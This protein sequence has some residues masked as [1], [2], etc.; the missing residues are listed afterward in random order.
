MNRKSIP[1]LVIFLIVFSSFHVSGFPLHKEN[2]ILAF[3]EPASSTFPQQVLSFSRS[4]IL[5]ASIDDYISATPLAAKHHIPL[6]LVSHPL[7]R[8][9]SFL[10]LYTP[11]HVY[12]VG[13]TPFDAT[14]LTDEDLLVETEPSTTEYVIIAKKHGEFSIVGDYLCAYHQGT[15]IYAD[16]L[17]D[18]I[19]LET[20]Q[21]CLPT[22][23]AL[24]W[25]PDEFECSAYV[26]TRLRFTCSLCT[27]TMPEFLL[28][29]LAR[30]D[31]DPYIDAT[32]GFITGS[33]VT[34]AT[35][36]LAR[37]IVYDDLMGD[38]KHNAL[39]APGFSTGETLCDTLD[40][41]YIEKEQESYHAQAFLDALNNGVKYAC[42]FGHGTPI[43]LL[44]DRT[45]NASDP[46]ASHL[47]SCPQAHQYLINRGEQSVLIPENYTIFPTIFC[48]EACLTGLTGRVYDKK[49]GDPLTYDCQ[50]FRNHSISLTL[51][52]SGAAAYIGSSTIGGIGATY[53]YLLASAYN[54]SL[55]DI[56]THMN[57]KFIAHRLSYFIIPLYLYKYDPRIVLFG[58]PAFNPSHDIQTTCEDYYRVTTQETRLFGSEQTTRVTIQHLNDFDVSFG[59]VEITA[60]TADTSSSLKL[61]N[62]VLLLNN[63]FHIHEFVSEELVGHRI[64]QHNEKIILYW[65]IDHPD[66]GMNTWHI[67]VTPER[68][69]IY[70]IDD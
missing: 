15:I 51:I 28:H 67:L 47:V 50:D 42:F 70:T 9:A 21:D 61:S 25:N 22:Y 44:F 26:K 66:V 4:V 45:R 36:L 53:P 69:W 2:T 55:G 46:H 6:I 20:L 48:M 23:C 12:A 60:D 35:L 29:T 54:W 16:S 31:D 19:I 63:I 5:A 64:E 59:K 24:V 33:D 39:F 65:T 18:P 8:I 41:T 49:T 10:S 7:T 14:P 43:N 32:F 17:D 11:D 56:V 3:T 37:E 40:L 27:S 30:I 38:W 58:D 68:P 52:R 34:D 1:V 57:N 13:E 62:R